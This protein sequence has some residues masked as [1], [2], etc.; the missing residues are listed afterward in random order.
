MVSGATPPAPIDAHRSEEPELSIDDIP[1]HERETVRR[2]I[3][4]CIADYFGPLDPDMH[5]TEIFVFGSFNDGTACRI[6]SDLDV[7]VLLSEPFGKEQS[8]QLNAT[9]KSYV[10]SRLPE[11]RTFG[12]VDP[13]CYPTDEHDG[14]GGTIL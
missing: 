2:L 10:T 9:V 5:V 3:E 8:K 1:D 13:Q 6:L 7:R 14:D 12:Y 11:G 4:E